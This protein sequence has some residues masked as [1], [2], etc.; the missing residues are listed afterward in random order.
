MRC[1]FPVLKDSG[2]LQRLKR[3]TD[4]GQSI[5]VSNCDIVEITVFNAGAKR[6]ESL[7]TRARYELP[8]TA[9]KPGA[10]ERGVDELIGK[11]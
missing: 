8:M 6:L 2:P 5:P 10:F 7:Y 11:V 1:V 9:G 3:G 4:E